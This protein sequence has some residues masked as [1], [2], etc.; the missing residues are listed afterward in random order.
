MLQY[1]RIL[2]IFLLAALALPTNAG[3]AG[4]KRTKP[5]PPQLPMKRAI[6]LFA[7]Q[8]RY[9]ELPDPKA[10][11]LT[12]GSNI[13]ER[14]IGDLMRTRDFA[15]LVGEDS[16]RL[17]LASSSLALSKPGVEPDPC[18]INP[19]P[20]ATSQI[21]IRINELSFQTGSRGERMFYGFARGQ[22]NTYNA[23]IDER[24]RN[25]FPFRAQ[26]ESINWFENV[27]ND[28]GGL[29]S[30]LELGH[31]I[32]FDILFAGAKL[33]HQRYHAELG[34]D[35][36]FQNRHGQSEHRQISATGNGFY[37]D[38]SAHLTYYGADY[39]AGVMIARKAALLSAFDRTINAVVR[40][41]GDE[42]SKLP[43][44]TR[45][46][47]RCQGANYIAAG[48][49]YR[50]P[51]GTRFYDRT[52]FNSGV[53]PAVVT[54]EQVFAHSS[55]VRVEGAVQPMA[56]D[57]LVSLQPS[58]SPPRVQPGVSRLALS[59]MSADQLEAVRQDI[60]A[61]DVDVPLPESLGG[62]VESYLTRLWQGLKALVTLPYRIWRYFQFDQDYKGGELWQVDRARA[63]DLGA[64][65]WALR[66]MGW[67]EAVKGCDGNSCLGSRGVVV[68]VI[69]SGIDY[70]HRELRRNIFWDGE[71]NTPG[72]DFISGDTRPYD[73]HA[74]GTEIASVIGGGGA[75]LVGVAP[76]TT[77]MAV[78]AFSPYGYTSS[79]ALYAAFSYAIGHGA[80]II[81]TGWGTQKN[82]RALEDAVALANANGVLVVAGAGDG[83]ADLGRK[84]YFPA[85]LGAPNLLVVAGHSEAGALTRTPGFESNYGQGVDL[86]APGQDVRVAN[87]REQ[88]KV[89][90]HTGL[91]AGFV[92]GAAAWLMAQCPKASMADIKNAILSG[93]RKLPDLKQ[94]VV[95]NK[96]L[97]LPGAVEVIRPICK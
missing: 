91:A 60:N 38:L 88:Y 79:S 13:Y 25:E 76:H 12:Y 73:D 90:S 70:N 54:V 50:V 77:L 96:A 58:E 43:L 32:N 83:G 62:F 29:F 78:K 27:F 37:Y 85:S 52:Q 6:E 72:F 97:Y 63:L 40:A 31:E 69:D 9:I 42:V 57:E 10:P 30:G 24:N 75:E 5:E 65:S 22:E 95:E 67:G 18:I 84:A 20:I 93:A 49:D 92:A 7:I 59:S 81:V 55:K 44:M 17:G 61:G 36:S 66:Q 15:V 82:S 64:R 53:T 35:V 8:D 89:R 23:G 26:P 51:V 1:R 48:A 46:A 74:H 28:H 68:A 87:P 11:V 45:Y 4:K 19:Q 56:G 21:Q 94:E 34:L 71:A 80:K 3:A 47:A 39:S 2:H 16:P 41:I 33:K 86:A 14:L